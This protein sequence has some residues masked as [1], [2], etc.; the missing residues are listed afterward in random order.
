MHM[1]LAIFEGV[2][3][4]IDTCSNA[5]Q[6]AHLL[7]IHGG[8]RTARGTRKYASNATRVIVEPTRFEKC[9]RKMRKEDS[10]ALLVTPEWVYT[11]VKAG[12]KQPSQYYS[13]DPSMFFS[14]VVISA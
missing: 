11:S 9:T 7:D 5:E 14:S 2:R 3:Y 1:A 10:R 6:I 8:K 4:Y 12:N 13:P